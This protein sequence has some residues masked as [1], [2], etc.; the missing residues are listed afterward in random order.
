MPGDSKDAPTHTYY[1][2]GYENWTHA[3]ICL[4]LRPY[5]GEEQRS[6]HGVSIFK[7]LQI[8]Q[9]QQQLQQYQQQQLQRYHQQQQLRQ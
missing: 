6:E 1:T 9:Q 8:H 2:V 7:Q 5:G 4:A 3:G